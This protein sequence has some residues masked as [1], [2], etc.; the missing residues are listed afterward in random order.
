MNVK[1]EE[2]QC[3]LC[4]TKYKNTFVSSAQAKWQ[5]FEKQPVFMV[6]ELNLLRLHAKFML[7]IM[8][9]P[10]SYFLNCISQIIFAQPWKV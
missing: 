4:L 5:I 2:K 10:V 9:G 8:H 1:R 7:G 6:R 3:R